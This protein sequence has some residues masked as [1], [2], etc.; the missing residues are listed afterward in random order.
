MPTSPASPP[1]TGS[2]PALLPT[3]PFCHSTLQR[4]KKPLGHTGPFGE[5]P[6]PP[7]TNLGQAVST[8]FQEVF[9]PVVPRDMIWV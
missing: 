2:T 7:S 9:F 8:T 6:D 4:R 1:G 5:E 3:P